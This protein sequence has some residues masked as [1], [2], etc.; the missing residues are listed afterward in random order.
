MRRLLREA[1]G[2]VCLVPG[3][4]TALRQ[5]RALSVGDRL[6]AEALSPEPSP[7]RLSRAPDGL[8]RVCQ[9]S[10][11]VA[12]ARNPKKLRAALRLAEPWMPEEWW[13]RG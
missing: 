5:R 12:R 9:G 11:E 7:V 13:T 2:Q 4:S 10:E 8:F 6:S 1:P 3:K